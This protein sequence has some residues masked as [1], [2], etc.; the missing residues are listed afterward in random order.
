[1]TIALVMAAAAL[2]LVAVAAI[3]DLRDARIPGWLTWPALAIGPCVWGLVGGPWPLAYAL[4]SAAACGLVPLVLYG[5][6]A[7]G[8]G[9]V[10]L[11]TAVGGFVG[12]RLGLEILLV[13]FTVVALVAVG[14]LVWRG[15]LTATLL[16]TIGTFLPRRRSAAQAPARALP[17]PLRRRVRFAPCV[18]VGALVALLPELLA[19]V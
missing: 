2:L 6:G 10:K 17:E 19:R 12:A 3:T 15:E 18:F 8:G 7:I 5:F 13:G 4:L 14:G 16:R 11:A 9:D 1:M